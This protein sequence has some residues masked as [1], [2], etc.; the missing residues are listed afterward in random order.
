M[1]TKNFL[2]WFSRFL[3]LALLATITLYSGVALAIIMIRTLPYLTPFVNSQA[4]VINNGQGS[5]FVNAIFQGASQAPWHQ[6]IRVD[7]ALPVFIAVA[8]IRKIG[9]L[10]NLI[11]R[12]IPNQNN[13]S[14]NSNQNNPNLYNL[15]APDLPSAGQALNS[16][17][18]GNA[19]Q[20]QQATGHVLN[21]M[22]TFLLLLLAALCIV[23]VVSIFRYLVVSVN[24]GSKDLLYGTAQLSDE[25][26]SLPAAIKKMQTPKKS[27]SKRTS[28]A[29]KKV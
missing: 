7:P 19:A 6:K 9:P 18:G 5:H 10:N 15:E 12:F 20:R 16:M 28:T 14:S 11:N 24:R 27:V 25:L 3:L 21:F 22:L 17:G 4:S 8:L 2:Y 23:L 29:K 13:S 1:T 26:K